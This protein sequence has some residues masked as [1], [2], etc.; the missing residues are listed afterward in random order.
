MERN[1]PRKGMGT[2]GEGGGKRKWVQEKDMN[3]LECAREGETWEE[4]EDRGWVGGREG[5]CICC[6]RGRGERESEGNRDE[7]EQG[8]E[9][10][11]SGG[12]GTSEL[13][14]SKCS[15]SHAHFGREAF[16]G[17]CLCE[18]RK[19]VKEGGENDGR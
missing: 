11:N 18:G 6:E 2:G 5:R 16:R 1:V 10:E 9:G 19:E 4:G 8:R 13:H 14:T 17:E 15:L 7:R 3:R 12:E